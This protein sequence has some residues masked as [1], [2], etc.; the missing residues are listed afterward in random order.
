MFYLGFL[1]LDFYSGKSPTPSIFQPPNRSA[2][3]DIYSR[4]YIDKNYPVSVEGALDCDSLNVDF[5]GGNEIA[6][7]SV[8]SVS[9]KPSGVSARGHWA[10][11]SKQMKVGAGG[12]VAGGGEGGTFEQKNSRWVTHTRG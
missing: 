10:K 11:R 4:R 7:V 1:L 12:G 2:V 6:C 8:V 3:T 9:F 5:K